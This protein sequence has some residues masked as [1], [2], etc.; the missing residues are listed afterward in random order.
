MQIEIR[1]GQK[2]HQ[3]GSWNFFFFCLCHLYRTC[4]TLIPCGDTRDIQV[5]KTSHPTC[6]IDL[7][8]WRWLAGTCW[9]QANQLLYQKPLENVCEISFCQ[10]FFKMHYFV[11]TFSADHSEV[12]LF[13]IFCQSKLHSVP[14]AKRKV[15]V[16]LSSLYCWS[17]LQ[18]WVQH[19]SLLT[20]GFLCFH[21]LKI[22]GTF[23]EVFMF[24][25]RWEDVSV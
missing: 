18:L 10:L 15:E 14:P 17:H 7:C 24:A 16:D 25:V 13:L 6:C 1:R 22:K 3:S 11:K 21:I 20:S 9:P 5:V 2:T 12:V 8:W 19:I 23:W 4:W